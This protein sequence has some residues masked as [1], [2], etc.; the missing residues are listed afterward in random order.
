MDNDGAASSPMPHM[1]EELCS[2][3][4]LLF[5]RLSWFFGGVRSGQSLHHEPVMRTAKSSYASLN[6]M[7]GLHVGETQTH[8]CLRI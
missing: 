1:V 5:P 6:G 4:E 7:D 2:A 3:W 8:R